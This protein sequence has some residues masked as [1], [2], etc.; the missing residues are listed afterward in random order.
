[1]LSECLCKWFYNAMGFILIFA[2]LTCRKFYCTQDLR[3][4]LWS[5]VCP[6]HQFV[7]SFW[8]CLLL[9]PTTF[10]NP[11]KGYQNAIAS[12]IDIICRVLHWANLTPVFRCHFRLKLT[13]VCMQVFGLWCHLIVPLVTFQSY[14]PGSRRIWLTGELEHHHLAFWP[15]A[16]RVKYSLLF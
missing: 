13:S 6:L 15:L 11:E 14:H 7:L 1:M 3:I 16:N 5:P 4:P 10:A 8:D 9:F 2:I 12:I